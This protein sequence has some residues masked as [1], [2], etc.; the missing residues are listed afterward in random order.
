MAR[1]LSATV[2]LYRTAIP[3]EG[4]APISFRVRNNYQEET[5][6]EVEIQD[7]SAAFYDSWAREVRSDPTVENAAAV[8]ERWL[9]ESAINVEAARYFLAAGVLFRLGDRRKANLALDRAVSRDP[10]LEHKASAFAHAV[11]GLGP[12]GDP[13]SPGRG[14]AAKRIE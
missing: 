8:V 12:V 13:V 10:L 14:G 7:R 11:G 4:K 1:A 2:S 6:I 5:R 9:P 3:I